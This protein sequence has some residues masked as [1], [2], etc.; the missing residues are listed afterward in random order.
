MSFLD[1]YRRS[2]APDPADEAYLDWLILEADRAELI[3]RI[4]DGLDLPPGILD[5][6]DA[7][8][9]RSRKFGL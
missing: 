3:R 5:E 8:V 9:G 6:R 2:G 4:M 1:R 7:S